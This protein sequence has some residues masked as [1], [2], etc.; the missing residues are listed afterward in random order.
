MAGLS[1]LVTPCLVVDRDKVEANA[2][3]LKARLKKLG[4]PLRLHVKTA[5]SLEAPRSSSTAK[6]T[7]SPSRR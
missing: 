3:R 4:V 5:K 6:K 1:Q 7:R 2:A